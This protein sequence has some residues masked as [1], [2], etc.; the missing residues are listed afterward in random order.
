MPQATDAAI[1]TKKCFF[2]LLPHF[3][4]PAPLRQS[5][6][7]L[8]LFFCQLFALYG[9]LVRLAL[10]IR[11][12]PQISH[13]P[14]HLFS[15][16][17]LGL[18]YDLT[19]ALYWSIPLAIYLILF[20]AK[21]FTSKWHRW[22]LNVALFVVIYILGFTAVAEW[23]FWDEFGVR[24]NFIAVDYLIYTNEVLGNIRE[25][26]P[27][28]LLLGLIFLAA[29]SFFLLLRCPYNHTVRAE[30]QATAP[31]FRQRLLHGAVFLLLPAL[32]FIAVDGSHTEQLSNRY[33]KE[34]A[35][36]GVYQ[37][38]AAFRNNTLDYKTF[39]Q[40]MD[41]GQA[42]AELRHQLKTDNATFLHPAPTEDITRAITA[43]G[44][45]SRHNVI[46]VM[47]ESMSAEYLGVFGN[48]QA[49]TPNL[50]QLAREGLLFTDLY[51]TGTRTVRG[52]EAV[53]LSV[54]PT[55]GRSIVK[56]PDNQQMFS[57][58]EIFR[59]KGYDNKFLYGG[60]GYFDNMN[61]FFNGNGFAVVD[62]NALAK[63]EI[64]F[65]NV[66]GVCDE[67]I[68]MRAVKEFD[69]SHREGKPFFG[70]L[71]TTSNHRPYTYPDGKIDV[72]SHT[73]RA[74]G[75]KYSDYAVGAFLRE[76][77]RHPWFDDTIFVFVADHCAGSAGRQEF[78]STVTTSR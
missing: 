40:T 58:G 32:T 36:D 55:P 60:Y 17:G 4:V 14:L 78:R 57:M 62:R 11:S 52:M 42:F 54:P 41:D 30:A 10:T 24:L 18:F 38:F 5:R 63:D 56:R 25:S 26:Y 51:A 48:Q 35:A 3:V 13:S 9:F 59:A 46:L 39:Y 21:A 71:M 2:P 20:P 73:G 22:F 44:K 64:T 70:F 45:E 68:Y 43:N 31:R 72:P 34:L 61:A 76:A 1:T 29:G 37:L 69:R 28:P 8:L 16:F 6:F 7:L 23:L 47:M 33:E 67:D 15:I 12:W 65:A 27:V 77:R 50:D 49:M 66:W 74:G 53:T 75:V 19:C